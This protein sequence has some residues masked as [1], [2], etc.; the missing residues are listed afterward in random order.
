MD[1]S[2]IQSVASLVYLYRSNPNVEL[3]ARLG[4]FDGTRFVS[5][6]TR[7]EMDA[8]MSMLQEADCIESDGEWTE[9][10]DFFYIYR[11]SNMRTR[12]SYD[13]DRMKT[14]MCTI[15]KKMLDCV[16]IVLGEHGIRVA[17]KFETPSSHV[18]SAINT[19]CMRIK[20]TQRFSLRHSSGQRYFVFD[21]SMTWSGKTKFE[22][23]QK[24]QTENPTYELEC[25]L[26]NRDYLEHTDDYISESLLLKTCDLL[27]S[28]L[29]AHLKSS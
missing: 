14:D 20:Q 13:A 21:F 5:G 26:V 6:V 22:A 29:E 18:P 7:S 1:T 17:V 19:T 28:N 15:E 25:E 9:T 3:E 8:I 23:E 16:D 11:T 24:Q 2:V 27:S 4:R 10:Q 12:V